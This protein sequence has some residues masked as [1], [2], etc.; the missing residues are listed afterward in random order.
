[1]S[2]RATLTATALAAILPLPVLAQADPAEVDALYEAMSFDALIDV[3]RAEGLDYGADI[4]TDMLAG[5]TPADWDATVDEIYSA[6]SMAQ[7]IRSGLAAALD[8]AD[9]PTITAFFETELGQEIIAL[10]V[11][12]REALLDD[13]VEEASKEAATLALIEETPRVE[14]LTTFIDAN[15]LVDT[16]VVGAMNANYAFYQGL[17]EGGGFP[18]DLSQDDILADVW[19]QEPEIRQN[20]TEWV[21][22]YLLM[23]YEPLSDEELQ[24]YIDFSQT[25]PGEDLNNALFAAFDD[26]FESISRD[27]GRATSEAMVGQDL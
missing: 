9:L 12:A 15:N 24:S 13:G 14:L 19:S 23:A 22:S 5:R 27:L 26:L 7:D 25:A 21:Y 18:A 17:L 1:M 8:G 16:N 10:E 4:G 11:A 2:L 20:T 6:E 3:M